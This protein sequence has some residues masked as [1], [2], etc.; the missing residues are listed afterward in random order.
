MAAALL[1]SACTNSGDRATALSGDSTLL[2]T[3]IVQNANTASGTDAG[4]LAKMPAIQFTDT[5]HDFGTLREGEQVVYEYRFTNTGKAPL[6]VAGTQ[7]SCGC[8]ASDY[9]KDPIAPGASAVIKVKFDSK[10]KTGIQDK[11][12]TVSTNAPYTPTLHIKGNVTG[13]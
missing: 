13:A 1:W 2:S 10:G 5:V 4:V 9:P 11:A 8:T 6:L 3:D 12:I 7:T